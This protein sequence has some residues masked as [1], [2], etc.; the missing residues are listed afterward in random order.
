FLINGLWKI[1]RSGCDY[2]TLE[3]QLQVL[4]QQ[5]TTRWG[6]D[7]IPGIYYY[8]PGW[9]NMPRAPRKRSVNGIYH[10]IMRGINR[11]SIFEDDEDCTKFIQTLQRYKKVCGYE[12]YAYCLMGN[13]LHMLLMEGKES[14]EQIMRRICGSYVFWYNQKYGRV[15]YLFQDRYMSE[16]VDDDKYF[17]TVLRYIYQNPVKAGLV[18]SVEDYPWSNYKE[19]TKRNGREIEFV[20]GM[21]ST[22]RDEAMKS[23]IE[24]VNKPNNDECL[25][26]SNKRKITDEEARSIIRKLCKI[27]PIDLQKLDMSTRKAYLSKIKKE[28]CISIRQIERITGINRGIIFRA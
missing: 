20:L 8:T 22:N 14:I 15:G 13:H 6:I 19:Y 10:I 24:Y 16:P 2:Q 21:F 26:I 4:S 12:L 9:K 11:Q 1:I 5:V 28:S 18:T 23:F 17:L 7:N 3:E 25:E 27:D